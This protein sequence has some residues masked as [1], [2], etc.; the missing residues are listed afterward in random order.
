[1]SPTGAQ[2]EHNKAENCLIAAIALGDAHSW[3][4][5]LLAVVVRGSDSAAL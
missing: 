5:S 2:V 3:R 4:G 1:M